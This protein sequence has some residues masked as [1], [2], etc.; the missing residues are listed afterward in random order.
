MHDQVR[1]VCLDQ[2]GSQMLPSHTGAGRPKNK[3]TYTC[4]AWSVSQLLGAQRCWQLPC[5]QRYTGG[6]STASPTLPGLGLVGLQMDWGL[7]VLPLSA[8][9]WLLKSH[10][11]SDDP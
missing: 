4:G 6:Q 5:Q 1:P 9:Y 3:R 7:Q 11:R 2:G 8:M 10:V